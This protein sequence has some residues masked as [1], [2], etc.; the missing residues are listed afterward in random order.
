M[1]RPSRRKGSPGTLL[2]G[3]SARQAQRKGAGYSKSSR[4]AR[5]CS[6]GFEKGVINTIIG[7]I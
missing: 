1:M 7:A 5:W 2:I 6:I 3:I 4:K